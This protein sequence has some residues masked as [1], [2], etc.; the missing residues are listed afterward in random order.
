VRPV[1]LHPSVVE[2]WVLAHLLWN[3]GGSAVADG[4]GRFRRE[5]FGSGRAVLREDV[6]LAMDPLLPLRSGSYRFTTEGVAASPCTFIDEGRLVTPVLGVKYARRLGLPPTAMPHGMDV[7]TFGGT[8]EIGIEEAAGDADAIVL[9]VLGIHT[10]DA[11][12]G[13]FSLSAPQCLRGGDRPGGRLRL[14]LS[15]N[16]FD[17]L[18]QPRLG[19]ARFPLETTPGLLFSC[20]VD[21]R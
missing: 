3:L 4:E 19:F 12:S 2:S 21:P 18:R 8:T 7:V 17:V 20:H 16:L 15:G 11:A 13:D 5:D 9:S 1:V 6:R 10:Q 14:T